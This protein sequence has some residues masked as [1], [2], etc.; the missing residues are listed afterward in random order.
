[1]VARSNPTTK[2]V[3]V[4]GGVAALEA[5]LALRELACDYVT[6]ELLAS[7]PLFSYRPASV[8]EP[9]GLG[10]ARHFELTEVAA[11]AGAGLTPGKLV[12]VDSAG[13]EGH[14]ADGTVVSYDCLLVACGAVSSVAIPGA[15]TFRGPA[16]TAAFS[17]LLAEIEAGNV[18]SIAFVVP[19]GATW[20]LPLYELALMTAA[21]LRARRINN[22]E[23]V[24][25][26]P[27]NEP[28][29]LFGRVASDTVRDL[30]DER[31]ISLHTGS[32][33][34][35]TGDGRLRLFPHESIDAERVVALPRLRGQAIAGLPQT[36]DG[37]I[38]VDAHGSVI[39]TN[40][41][42][43][44]GDVTNFPVKQGGIAAQQALAA[45]EAIAAWSGADVEPRP[46]RPVLRG[47][48]LTGAQPRYL[49]REIGADE[50]S[51]WASEAPIWWPPA[52]IVGRHLAPF[53]ATLA[54]AGIPAEE[55][56]A[57]GA[58]RVDV[59]L[60]AQDVDQLASRRLE[61]FLADY[62]AEKTVVTVGDV[63]SREPLIVA[64]E[65]T[66]G[67]VAERMSQLDVGS[68]LVAQYGQLIG[69]LTARDLLHA[70]AGRVHSSDARVRQWMTAQP[71]VV[72]ADT[73]IDKAA[74]LM[75]EY[76][77]HHLPVTE[78]QR[79]VGM[80]GLRAAS[81]P[82]DTVAQPAIGLGF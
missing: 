42:F 68:A 47:M 4:G 14:L 79:P 45:A 3:I 73:T 38:P 20:A 5:A 36:I 7:E 50:E 58:I 40:D 8:A 37:F 65:D 56:V 11:A 35:E 2:V 1:M 12:S 27:E 63:M 46:F 25:V 70:L 10:E 57:E 34:S 53:L 72:T 60:A 80:I 62:P 17:G 71:I 61:A 48:L 76:G 28:L 30:L 43:A 81:R 75:T 59:E 67:E 77:V 54:G 29:E 15:L 22:V 74:L 6:V 39:D 66:L 32:F 24:L 19:W 23:L 16:D 52:K 41:V 44:A 31:G 13:H 64:P 21:W 49:R 9:F 69:I 51:S 82:H 78:G 18:R 26:T 33:A 55:P